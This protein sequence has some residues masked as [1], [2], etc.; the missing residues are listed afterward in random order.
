MDAGGLCVMMAGLQETLLW[1]VVSL[2][3]LAPAVHPGGQVPLQGKIVCTHI[4]TCNS[5]T[6]LA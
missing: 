2:G 6:T 3:L 1:L 4:A 5:K